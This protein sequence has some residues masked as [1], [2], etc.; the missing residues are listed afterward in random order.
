MVVKFFCKGSL[1]FRFVTLLKGPKGPTFL[2]LREM[3]C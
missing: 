2:P 1:L 3:R